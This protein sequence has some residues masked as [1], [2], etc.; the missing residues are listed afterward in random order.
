VHAHSEQLYYTS[1]LSELQIYDILSL[2]NSTVLTADVILL[3]CK[4]FFKLTLQ[5]WPRSWRYAS[6]L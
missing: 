1:D 5:E 6:Y 3:M 2:T 4:A